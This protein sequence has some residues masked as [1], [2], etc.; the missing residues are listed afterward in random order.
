MLR[1]GDLPF[2]VEEIKYALG[3]GAAGVVV[4]ALLPDG[5]LDREALATLREAAQGRAITLHRAI[6]LTPDLLAAVE[7][8]CALGYD[9]ILSSGGAPTAVEGSAMLAR[10]VQAARGR[11]SIMPGSGVAPENVGAL[12]ADTGAIEVHASASVADIAPET[13]AVRL[14]F[15]RAGR[16]ITDAKSVR[17]LRAAIDLHQAAFTARETMR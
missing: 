6:D 5:Q 15:A 4:G 13:A 10:M 2:M 3:Q 1:D 9:K 16:R 8:A 7:Q 17:R 14:G 12:L 11:L